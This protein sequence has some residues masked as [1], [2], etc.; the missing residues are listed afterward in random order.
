MSCTM[1]TFSFFFFFFHSLARNCPSANKIRPR[2][3]VQTT[4]EN[5]SKGRNDLEIANNCIFHHEC[6]KRETKND[7]DDN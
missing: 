4:S 2:R 3:I 7:D 5:T 1:Q 6:Q